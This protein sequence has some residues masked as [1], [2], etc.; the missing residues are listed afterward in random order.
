[1]RFLVEKNQI[2][3]L[4]YQGLLLPFMYFGIRGKIKE[5][6]QIEKKE[7]S[8]LSQGKM[9]AP[10]DGIERPFFLG[11]AMAGGACFLSDFFLKNQQFTGDN[12][13]LNLYGFSS[14][15]SFAFMISGD[16]FKSQIPKPPSNSLGKLQEWYN[17]LRESFGRKVE[18]GVKCEGIEERVE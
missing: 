4:C 1:M 13:L 18:V 5:I 7:Y 16:Y 8:D 2:N 17:G 3:F 14:A 11:I 6:D 12:L 10:V 15:F 9:Y